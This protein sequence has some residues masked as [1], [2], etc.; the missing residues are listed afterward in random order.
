VFKLLTG[1]RCF[2]PEDIG[3]KE[4]LVCAD[5]I[6][7]VQDKIN[8]DVPWNIEMIDYRCSRRP[9]RQQHY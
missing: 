2:V 9:I 1:G 4:I 8:R 7:L 6:C 5:K 3:I